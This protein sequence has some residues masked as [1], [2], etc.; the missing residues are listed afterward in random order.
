MTRLKLIG[1]VTT[2]FIVA[3]C[4]SEF[5]TQNE[6]NR[7]A[8]IVGVQDGGFQLKQTVGPNGVDVVIQ[9]SRNLTKTERSGVESC[10]EAQV[11]ARLL[12]TTSKDA[13]VITDIDAEPGKLP[14]PTQFPLL[15]EDIAIWNQLT[16]EQQERALLFLANG[17]T[18]S[19]SLKAD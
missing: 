7:C 4:T 16:L 19:A 9:Q 5:A 11:N 1:L 8:E 6:I 15:P 3:G 2:S 14:L 17:S 13:V 10:I 12:G 18:I